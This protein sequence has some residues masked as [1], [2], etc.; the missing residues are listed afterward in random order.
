[1][2]NIIKSIFIHK[3]NNDDSNNNNNNNNNHAY[4]YT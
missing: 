4:T 1:M 3:Y 2:F